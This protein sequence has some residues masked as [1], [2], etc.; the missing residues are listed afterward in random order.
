M[1]G[2]MR[3]ANPPYELPD[4]A[5]CSPVRSLPTLA[6]CYGIFDGNVGRRK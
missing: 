2:A 4:G 3:F 5:L 1:T 6:S